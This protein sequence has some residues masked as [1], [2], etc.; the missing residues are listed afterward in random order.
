MEV[1][2]SRVFHFNIILNTSVEKIFEYMGWAKK[3]QFWNF[4]LLDLDDIGE[5]STLR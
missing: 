4:T 1:L 5:A 3:Q 2:K